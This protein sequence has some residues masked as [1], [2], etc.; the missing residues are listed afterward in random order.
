MHLLLMFAITGFVLAIACAIANLLRPSG[1][2]I[3]GDV[4][5]SFAGCVIGEV[6]TPPLANHSSSASPEP[7]L[8][9]QLG[10]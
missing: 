1:R 3:D 6:D 9:W 10:G 5:P 2:S 4:G 7:W 8:R